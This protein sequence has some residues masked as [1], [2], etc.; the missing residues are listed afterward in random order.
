MQE[1]TLNGWPSQQPWSAEITLPAGPT[2]RLNTALAREL[3]A[4]LLQTRD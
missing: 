4:P 1:I 2:I 3:I